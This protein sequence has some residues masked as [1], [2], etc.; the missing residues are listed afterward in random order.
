MRRSLPALALLLG[1]VAAAQA[2]EFVRIP[3]RPFL[4]AQTETTVEQFA[5]FVKTTGY[6]TE[7]EV[8]SAARTW[9]SPGFKLDKKQPVVYVTA[10]DAMAYCEFADARL[11][12]DE[13]WEYA[14]RSGAAARH[15]WGDTIDAAFL[16]YRANS[17]GHP[18]RVAGK[19]PND[20]GLFDVEGNVWEWALSSTAAN[21]DAMA[22][23]RGGSWI[24]CEDIEG[25][26]GK[27]PGK[28]IGLS[29]YFKVPIK[30]KHRY[31]DIGFRCARDH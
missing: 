31:D 17:G 26:P 12:T 15:Y 18:H 13:E 24:D 27:P 28:L 2:P 9:R 8:E 14:A 29:T 22:N 4:M 23:R 6:R 19:R 21:G 1:A 5:A 10:N 25:G 3:D 7:A 20:W 11:P 30:L 16:W